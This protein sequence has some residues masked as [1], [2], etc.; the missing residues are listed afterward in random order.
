[1][2]RA[3]ADQIPGVLEGLLERAR[4]AE[5]LTPLEDESVQPRPSEIRGRG[6]P[7]VAAA[8]DDRVPLPG[9]EGGQRLGQAHAPERLVDVDHTARLTGAAPP[10]SVWWIG[11]AI[12]TSN[13]QTLRRR[14]AREAP[15]RDH[16]VR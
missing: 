11:D 7:V 12:A 2:V 5:L 16:Q 14:G 10:R 3:R 15:I 8:D 1:H 6:Q 4:A 9:G 13:P